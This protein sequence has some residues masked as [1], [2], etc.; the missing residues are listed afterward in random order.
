MLTLRIAVVITALFIAGCTP[1]DS[2]ETS[3]PPAHTK[4]SSITDEEL[5]LSWRIHKTSFAEIESKNDLSEVA[6]EWQAF[7]SQLKPADE[8]WYFRSPPATWQHLMGWEGY[9]IFRD[10]KLVA[11]FTTREN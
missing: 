8:L 11:T 2:A 4:S 7:K 5:V 3:Y 9:A 10:D 1:R 6:P